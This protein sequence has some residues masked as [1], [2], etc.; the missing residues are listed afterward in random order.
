MMMMGNIIY[1]DEHRN[2]SII[3][4][5]PAWIHIISSGHLRSAI[6]LH[7]PRLLI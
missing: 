7:D 2:L 6:P 5:D 3:N 1:Y 4:T